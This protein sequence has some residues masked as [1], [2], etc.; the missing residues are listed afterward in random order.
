MIESAKD[1]GHCL[2]EAVEATELNGAQRLATF[3]DSTSRRSPE[4]IAF[5]K[6]FGSL[7]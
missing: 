2:N 3:F 7:C 5:K 6:Q 4:D 1:S